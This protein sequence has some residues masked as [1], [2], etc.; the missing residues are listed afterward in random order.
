MQEMDAGA[1]AQHELEQA[2]SD[3]MKDDDDFWSKRRCSLC[4]QPHHDDGD[5]RNIV[6]AG[7]D[8]NDL[9]ESFRPMISRPTPLIVSETATALSPPNTAYIEPIIPI[10]TMV[11]TSAGNRPTPSNY[12]TSN[13]CSTAME[14]EYNTPGMVISP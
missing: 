4:K 14:P 13:S 6:E 5:N 2:V 12:S 9:P 10:R 8:A 3:N 7:E 1:F 11:N